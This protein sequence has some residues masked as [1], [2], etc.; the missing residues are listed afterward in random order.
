MS[1]I[2]MA[3]HTIDNLCVPDTS[4]EIDIDQVQSGRL[5]RAQDRLAEAR[6]ARIVFEDSYALQTEFM[7]RI[8]IV[9]P[10]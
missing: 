3:H 2:E 6:G 7:C 9:R 8:S 5:T 4:T 10:T 1:E